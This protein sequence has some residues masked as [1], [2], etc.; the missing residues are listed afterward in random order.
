[1]SA[2]VGGSHSTQETSAI[3]MKG[4]ARDV[5]SE[6]ILDTQEIGADDGTGEFRHE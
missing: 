4:K 6:E 2:V 5:V 3:L 1:M